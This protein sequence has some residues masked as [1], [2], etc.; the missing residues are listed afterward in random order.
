MPSLS[1]PTVVGSSVKTIVKTVSNRVST[2]HQQPNPKDE[3]SSNEDTQEDTLDDPY[4]KG[5]ARHDFKYDIGFALIKN[6]IEQSTHHTVEELQDFV[7][8][9]VPS[10]PWI[11][12]IKVTIPSKFCLKAADL[13]IQSDPGLVKSVGG[14]T[15]WQWTKNDHGIHAEWI[16]PKSVWKGF[17]NGQVEEEEA[18]VPTLFFIHGGG[19]FFGS[20]DTHRYQIWRMARKAKA[21]AFTVA[22]RLAPQYPFPC[23]LMDCLSAYLYLTEPNLS[24]GYLHKPISPKQIIISGDSA[25][26]NLSLSLLCV[27]RN[28]GKELP[29]GGVLISPWVDLTH[30]FESVMENGDKDILPPNGFL[31]QPSEAWPPLPQPSKTLSTQPLT[32]NGDLASDSGTSEAPVSNGGSNIHNDLSNGNS[33]P[34]DKDYID[35]NA[36]VCDATEHQVQLY[37]TNLQLNNPLVSPMYQTSLG[38]LCPLLIIASDH[39]CLRDEV[40]YMAHRAAKPEQYRLSSR[41]K[42]RNEID[43]HEVN[44]NWNP[45]LVHLQVYDSTCHMFSVMGWTQPAKYCY[46]SMGSFCR[47]VI[48]LQKEKDTKVSVNEDFAND[49]IR[50]GQASDPDSLFTGSYLGDKPFKRPEF[51]SNMVR[52]R[53]DVE[54]NS[55]SLESESEMKC[56]KNTERLKGYIPKEVIERFLEG[57][58]QEPKPKRK[59]KM[60]EKIYE[61]KKKREIDDQKEIELE[62]LVEGLKVKEV[63]PPTAIAGRIETKEGHALALEVQKQIASGLELVEPK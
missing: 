15:W 41:L 35:R 14:S 30:S 47:F 24:E 57:K 9:S 42:E 2:H 55:R 59:S 48:D 45:T 34:D 19:F 43:G 23:A 51:E 22:Y 5:Q 27:L 37:A 1:F 54:G 49:K 40:I 11:K 6:F 52:E 26:G 53:I 20:L 56:L 7:T 25:G 29:S 32:A 44:L 62:G 21:R 63:P 4:A 16:A 58:K 39:E 33:S 13:L 3:S 50:N 61:M 12:R 28:L 17:P 10:P 60:I 46:R 8:H 31:Y 38:G 18:D 36:S